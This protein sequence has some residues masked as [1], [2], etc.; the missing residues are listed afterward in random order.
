MIERSKSTDLCEPPT[1]RE[2]RANAVNVSISRTVARP[3]A[4]WMLSRR[5]AQQDCRCKESAMPADGIFAAISSNGDFGT[6]RPEEQ[7]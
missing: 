7:L 2:R 3:R 5:P 6:S 1:V 4:L